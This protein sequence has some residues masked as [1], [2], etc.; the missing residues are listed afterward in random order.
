MAH[1]RL[2]A[3]LRFPKTVDAMNLSQT[4]DVGLPAPL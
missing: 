4:A 1:Q 3:R 2:R